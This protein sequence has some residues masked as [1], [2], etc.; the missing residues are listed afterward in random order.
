VFDE[1]LASSAWQL[2][3]QLAGGAL[4][5]GGIAVLS[6]SSIVATETVSG[7][8][9]ALARMGATAALQGHTVS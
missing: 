7:R 5:V 4:A 3:V 1:K 2:G 8:E 9:R 6:R